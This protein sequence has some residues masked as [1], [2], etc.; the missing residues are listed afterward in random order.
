MDKSDIDWFLISLSMWGYSLVGENE[1]AALVS[2]HPDLVN[3]DFTKKE[4][5]FFLL[6][7]NGKYSYPPYWNMLTYVVLAVAQDKLSLS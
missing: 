7:N 3:W 5:E 1:Y 2:E 6:N 4:R